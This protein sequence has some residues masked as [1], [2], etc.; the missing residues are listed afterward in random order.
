MQNEQKFESVLW[1]MEVIVND[2]V[3][4]SAQNL[5]DKSIGIA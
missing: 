1:P 5:Q 4:Y 3:A 2:R